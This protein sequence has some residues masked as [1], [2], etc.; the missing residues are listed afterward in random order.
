MKQVYFLTRDKARREII[1]AQK[2]EL[3]PMMDGEDL[4]QT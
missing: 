2:D 1:L 3:V 4:S